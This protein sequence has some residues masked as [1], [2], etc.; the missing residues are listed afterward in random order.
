MDLEFLK[1]NLDQFETKS[2]QD[3]FGSFDRGFFETLVNELIIIYRYISC[4]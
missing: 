1:I 3:N 4:F 2:L